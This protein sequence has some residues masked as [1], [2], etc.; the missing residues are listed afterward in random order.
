MSILIN[1]ISAATVTFDPSAGSLLS[2][3]FRRLLDAASD[4]LL[5]S[6]VTALH[7]P[8]SFP[9]VFGV[10]SSSPSDVVLGLDWAAYLRDSLISLGHRLD[11]T[12]DAWR[13]LAD[14]SCLT[15]SCTSFEPLVSAPPHTAAATSISE[16]S[17]ASRMCEFFNLSVS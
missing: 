9:L 7:G 2:P 12:F 4:S 13:F 3:Q 8:I 10:S 6:T 1:G 16:Y 17:S 14:P 5:I 11:S 15:L